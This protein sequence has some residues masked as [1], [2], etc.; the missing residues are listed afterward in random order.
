LKRRFANLTGGE[1][2]TARIIPRSIRQ[3]QAARTESIC[4]PDIGKEAKNEWCKL[5]LRGAK[6]A[7]PLG[8]VFN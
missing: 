8:A 4:N 7:S 5:L 1:C 6:P 2:G 3:A